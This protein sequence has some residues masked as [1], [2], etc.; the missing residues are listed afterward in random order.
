MSDHSRPHSRRGG[1]EGKICVTCGAWKPLLAFAM[2]RRESDGLCS[3]CREC[4]NA[5]D[6]KFRAKRRRLGKTKPPA[7]HEVHVTPVGGKS[8]P[9]EF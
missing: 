3:H 4:H 1:I 6:A 5:I 9:G 8:D 7:F 2:N